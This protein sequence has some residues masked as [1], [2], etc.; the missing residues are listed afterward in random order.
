[1]RITYNK[2]EVNVVLGTG[3]SV[4]LYGVPSAYSEDGLFLAVWGSAELEPLPACDG[5]AP[6]LRVS[7][8]EG[9][10]GVPAVAEHFK[11]KGVEY[12]AN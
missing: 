11:A 4:A 12:A 7:M 5:A 9:V 10:A 2:Q 6:L 8:I 1:M 3:D